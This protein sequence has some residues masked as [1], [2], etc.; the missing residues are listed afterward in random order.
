MRSQPQLPD[1]K[2]GSA[3]SVTSGQRRERLHEEKNEEEKKVR[4]C[5]E[6]H[7]RETRDE[8]C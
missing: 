4:T 1:T 3:A 8:M 6:S 7:G 5:E 2:S